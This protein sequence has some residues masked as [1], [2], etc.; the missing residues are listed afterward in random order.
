MLL[1]I[2]C[3]QYAKLT[4]FIGKLIDRKNSSAISSVARVGPA[5][6]YNRRPTV[7]LNAHALRT[8][9]G[10]LPAGCTAGY[11][12]SRT[13]EIGLSE[14]AGVHYRSIVYLVDACSAG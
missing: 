8:L 13:C 7:E 2:G 1:R 14:H 9:P 12:T 6:E 5:R 10:S 4:V 3:H 11:S